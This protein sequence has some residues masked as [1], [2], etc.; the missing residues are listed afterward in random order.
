MKPECAFRQSELTTS[1]MSEVYAAQEDASDEIPE[2]T[3][4][5]DLRAIAANYA[6]RVREVAQEYADAA[7]AMGG[8]G[9]EMQERADELENH[10]DEV[11]NIEFE[12]EM[13]D[14]HMCNALDEPNPECE[15]CHGTGEIEDVDIESARSALEEAIGELS[16]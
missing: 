9:E 7:D 15:Q 6:E 11:E 14:C 13:V 4:V 3:C 10:A 5:E 16:L 2:A 1:K 8:A 12:V